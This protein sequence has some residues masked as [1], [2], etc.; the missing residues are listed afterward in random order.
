VTADAVFI[1]VGGWQMVQKYGDVDEELR[2][3]GASVGVCDITGRSMARVKSFDLESV[4]GEMTIEVGSVVRDGERVIARLTSEE[5]LVIGAPAVGTDW[6]GG[7]EPEGAPAGAPI[8]SAS[9]DVSRA[10]TRSPSL[11]TEPTS[12]VI[13]PSTLSRS[14]DFTRAIDRPVISQT[15][16]EAPT[17]RN[18]S[19]TS[20]Y[21]CTICQPPTPIKTASAV[22]CSE[23][24]GLSRTG[25]SEIVKKSTPQPLASRI[26]YRLC[27]NDRRPVFVATANQ[28]FRTLACKLFWHPSQTKS[29]A[30]GRA[31]PQT[32]LCLMLYESD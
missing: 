11:T 17:I 4:L 2:I 12:I 30:Q 8:T 23:C 18:S 3:V 5:A 20:P 31:H 14:K 32:Q 24:S 1:G 28:Y 7:I 13:S 29:F 25:E 16:T 15:P 21:F 27:D 6:S 26:V 9:S 22:T 10:I 19:S